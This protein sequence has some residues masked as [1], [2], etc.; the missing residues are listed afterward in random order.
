MLTV[1]TG[2]I[3]HSSSLLQAPHTTVEETA[4]ETHT[5]GAMPPHSNNEPGETEREHSPI[6]EV[7]F[8]L[9]LPF[10]LTK[11]CFGYTAIN[12]SLI[13]L[14]QELGSVIPEPASSQGE[15]ACE[16]A[17]V[18]QAGSPASDETA[19]NVSWIPN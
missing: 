3:S 14:H 4:G 18:P 7:T 6:A 17:I 11:P 5:E 1:A 12:R 10:A 8:N 16:T 9:H 15:V 2:Y 13:L 19:P